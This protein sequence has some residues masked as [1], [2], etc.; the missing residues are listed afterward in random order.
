MRRSSGG[1]GPSEEEDG[2]HDRWQRQPLLPPSLPLH[3]DNDDDDEE[4][5]ASDVTSGM[6][7]KMAPP[8]YAALSSTT[9]S[10]Q[11]TG[12]INNDNDRAGAGAREDG[13]SNDESSFESSSDAVA[14]SSS[15]PPHMPLWTIVCILSTAFAYGCIL[16]T[17]FM[18]TLPL[19]CERIHR[20]HPNQPTSVA[21]GVFV[22][23]AGI[24][25]LVSP[26]VGMWSDNYTSP[27]PHALGRR[28]PYLVLGSG[29]T[30]VGLLGQLFASYYGFWMRYSLAFF[31]HMI[32]LNIMYAMMIAL[33]PDQ[34]PRSQTGMANGI[35]AL[36][37]VLGS[38]FG[39]ALFHSFLSDRLQNMYGLYICLIVTASVT[40]GTHAHDADAALLAT[41]EDGRRHCA[42]EDTTA[43]ES[44]RRP[45]FDSSRRP[46]NRTSL[47]GSSSPERREALMAAASAQVPSSSSSS[48]L[49]PS[50]VS[51]KQQRH[52][53]WHHRA[54]QRA[55]QH[56][57][58]AAQHAQQVLVVTPTLILK[59][60]LV[61]PIQKTNWETV[62]HSYWI[63]V[64]KYHDFAV[65]TASRLFYYCGMS[66]QTFFLYYVQDVVGITNHPQSVVATLA[67]VGQLAGATTC[68]PVGYLSDHCPTHW[69][70]GTVQNRRTPF[71][72]GAC[73]VLS[74]GTLALLW[75]RSLPH[76][77][78]CSAILGAANGVYITMDTSLAVDALP[79]HGNDNNNDEDGTGS[80]QLLGVWGVAA[81]LG[82]TLG[83]VRVSTPNV[84]DSL[85]GL[86]FSHFSVHRTLHCIS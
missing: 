65:V 19:E 60:V 25:Q 69:C 6:T 57:Q 68:L 56:A 81:F 62:Q 9:P 13:D 66:V 23:L 22:S 38:L 74:A 32:G 59:S 51:S 16:T 5:A 70:C 55:A 78:L 85:R 34:I 14:A 86:S 76:L 3:H 31:L 17:L 29:C 48:S 47:S 41:T 63:D 20:D 52:R 71:V 67:M 12:E 11:G 33:I 18:I 21:L 50:R 10:P 15:P 80:A 39:F 2:S 58:L 77:M 46:E 26:L 75:V 72:Y 1:G 36:E 83:P 79:E 44:H 45:N 42:S 35:L 49:S 30:I 4:G 27:T 53:R 43:P 61:D 24:T 82:A 37:L 73:V 7:M 40:T 84:L 54:A 28:L 8:N 64:D